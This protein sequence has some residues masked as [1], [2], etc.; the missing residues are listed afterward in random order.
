[1]AMGDNEI[2]KASHRLIYIDN[3]KGFLILL[4]VFGHCL[5]DTGTTDENLLYR[6]IYSFHMPL[7][8]AVSGFVSYHPQL[9][10][11]T[12]RRRA[13]QLLLPFMAWAIVKSLLL[14]DISYVKTIILYPDRGLWFLHALFFIVI[15]LT[16]CDKLS[17][18]TKMSLITIIIVVSLLL[19]LLVLGLNFKLF[20]L[21]FVAFHFPFFCAGFFIRKYNLIEKMNVIYGIVFMALFLVLA[22]W[23]CSSFSPTFLS[24]ESKGIVSHLVFRSYQYLVAFISIPAWLYLLKNT[25]CGRRKSLLTKFGTQTLALYAISLSLQVIHLKIVY[26]IINGM[27]YYVEVIFLFVS[28]MIISYCLDM[29]LSKNKYMSFVF[30]GKNEFKI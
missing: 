20:G 28:L 3:L 19:S 13:W 29:L 18:K 22:Y 24:I 17:L 9:Q 5:Q 8:M 25:K 6:Y 23:D 7:F 10:W 12:V 1:M 15:T 27:P 21:Q 2:S 26:P 11:S 14:G 4:V 16:I 30:L